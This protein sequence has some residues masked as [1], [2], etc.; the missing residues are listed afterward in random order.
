MKKEKLVCTYCQSDKI[1]Y[2]P[3]PFQGQQPW[4]DVRYE[5]QKNGKFKAVI[6]GDTPEKENADDKNRENRPTNK[7][8]SKTLAE[9]HHNRHEVAAEDERPK[10]DRTFE[11]SPQCCKVVN[12]R[13]FRRTV[14][15]NVQHREVTGNE[16]SFHRDRSKDPSEEDQPRIPT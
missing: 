14:I 3:T 1:E 16:C 10:D 2:V 6:K 4:F 11:G 7:R 13:G 12:R 9:L 15:G 8:I 5:Q